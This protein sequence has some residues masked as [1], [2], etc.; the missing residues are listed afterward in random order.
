MYEQRYA[1][2]DWDERYRDNG[3]GTCCPE[4]QADG[5]PCDEIR[6]CVDCDRAPAVRFLADFDDAEDLADGAGCIA[7][8]A[9]GSWGW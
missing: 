3:M 9:M 4:T 7:P 5:V 2:G 6:D 8:T 1:P